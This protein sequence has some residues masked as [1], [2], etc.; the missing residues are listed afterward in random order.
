ML[1]WMKLNKT[2]KLVT[3]E[4][5][6]GIM[7]SMNMINGFSLFVCLHSLCKLV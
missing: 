7:S 3:Q 5:N 4:V 6:Q 1:D 2:K